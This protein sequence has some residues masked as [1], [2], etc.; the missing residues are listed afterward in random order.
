MILLCCIRCI[1]AETCSCSEW[2]I[3]KK[4][5]NLRCKICSLLV[6]CSSLNIRLFLSMH[7]M[8]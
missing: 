3:W 4:A 6:N 5:M 1:V 2:A 7:I 8:G